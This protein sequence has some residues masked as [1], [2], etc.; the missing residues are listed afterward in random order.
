M[1]RF[2]LLRHEC[3]QE[4]PKPSHWDLMLEHEGKLQTWELRQLPASWAQQLGIAAGDGHDSLEIHPLADHRME[5]LEYEGQIFGN[6][7][8]VTRTD[9]GNYEM[10]E[11]EQS[12]QCFQLVGEKI[13]STITIRQTDG[14]W[15][16][17]AQPS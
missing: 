14:K 4:F 17:L 10:L 2:V 1:P 3:P 8:S 13:N 5:Y 16:M 12:L 7:G 15:Q 9:V 6:R 11:T